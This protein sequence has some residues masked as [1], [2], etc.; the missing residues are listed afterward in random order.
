MLGQTINLISRLATTPMLYYWGE[1]RRCCELVDWPT[2][3][4]RACMGFL[5]SKTYYQPQLWTTETS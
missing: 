4:A 1:T 2:M 5:P 3:L